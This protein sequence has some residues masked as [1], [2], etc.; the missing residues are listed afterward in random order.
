MTASF[1]MVY[2]CV[3]LTY[4]YL[5]LLTYTY[6]WLLHEITVLFFPFFDYTNS[7][8]TS[9]TLKKNLFSNLILELLS[10]YKSALHSWIPH[11]DPPFCRVSLR[12]QSH[13]IFDLWFFVKKYNWAHWLAR[14][15]SNKNSYS[16]KYCLWTSTPR[17]VT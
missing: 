9:Q 1:C 5:H 13:E 12:G 3:L 10:P 11:I 8:D 4:T 15:V 14:A 16:W 17:Y 6:A 2:L 7:H